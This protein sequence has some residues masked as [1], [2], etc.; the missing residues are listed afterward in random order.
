[1]RASPGEQPVGPLERF[2]WPLV[3]WL[4]DARHLAGE[5]E[6]ERGYREAGKEGQESDELGTGMAMAMRVTRGCLRSDKGR[7]FGHDG[8][9]MEGIEAMAVDR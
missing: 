2:V 7:V 5:D 4:L 1:M 8:K 6:N 3:E 9:L